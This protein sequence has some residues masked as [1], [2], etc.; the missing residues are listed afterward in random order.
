MLRNS[1]KLTLIILFCVFPLC[2]H[3]GGWLTELKFVN[4]HDYNNSNNNINNKNDVSI[5]WIVG[6]ADQNAIKEEFSLEPNIKF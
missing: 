4:L 2:V 5:K 6:P 3:I 1:H